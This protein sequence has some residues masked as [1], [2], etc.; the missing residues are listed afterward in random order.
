M[1]AK[2][3]LE[4]DLAGD[5]DAAPLRA[6]SASSPLSSHLAR[7]SDGSFREG[8]VVRGGKRQAMGGGRSARIAFKSDAAERPWRK[9]GRGEGL[10]GGRGGRDDT[11]ISDVIIL[12]LRRIS[13]HVTGFYWRQ[14]ERSS[15]L[16]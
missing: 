16:C 13:R 3:L 10:G 5:S 6:P 8:K 7:G 11:N 2:W 12:G 4:A 14:G 1:D 15:C 9:G